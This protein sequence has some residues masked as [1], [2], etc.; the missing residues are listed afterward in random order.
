MSEGAPLAGKVALVTGAA[1]RRGIGRGIAIVLA[2]AGADVA[3]NDVAAA[4]EGQERVR[5]LQ[6]MGRRGVFVESDVRSPQAVRAMFDRVEE[7]LGPVDVFVNN[8]GVCVWQDMVDVDQSAFDHIMGVNLKGAMF[9]CREAASRMVRRER[10]G[11]IVIISS[12]HAQMPFPTMSIY[13]ATKSGLRALSDNLALELAPHGITVNHVGPGWVDSDI[14]N[15][16]PDLQTD[17]D[18]ARTIAAIPLHRPADPEE[19]GQAVR[20]LVS[21]AGRYVTGAYIRVDGGFVVGKYVVPAGVR[22]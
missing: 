12:V 3:V 14:N 21:D 1:R 10:G 15:A 2:R 22:S 19:I 20:Y 18:R 11:S 6:A 8:A 13:G 5:E 9:A 16:S 17:E 7:T 4:E